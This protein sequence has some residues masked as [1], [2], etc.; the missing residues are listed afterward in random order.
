MGS[1]RRRRGRGVDDV[2]RLV[3][4]DLIE[5]AE[6]RDPERAVVVDHEDFGHQ[7]R[8]GRVMVKQVPAVSDATVSVPP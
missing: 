5:Q 1:A 6:Q 2:A 4:P 3:A 7:L 8:S